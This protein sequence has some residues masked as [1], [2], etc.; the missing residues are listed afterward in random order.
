MEKRKISQLFSHPNYIDMKVDEGG[1]REWRLT[2]MYGEF[3]WDKKQLT[4]DCF[5]GLHNQHNLPWVVI[6]DL[7]EIM[8]DH[9]KEG[10]NPRHQRYLNA[11]SA[12]MDGCDLHDIGYEGE[13]FTW[14]HGHVREILDRAVANTQWMNMMPQATL[15]NLPFSRLDQRPLLLCTYHASQLLPNF[16]PVKRF[17]ARWLSEENF[18]SI[19]HDAWEESSVH[20][21]ATD[22]NS[23][24]ANLHGK[25]HQW[26]CA[27]L[28][29]PRKAR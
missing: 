5:H 12:T 13:L 21:P 3:K 24:L 6:G 14:Q 17:E 10:G 26:D 8:I 1:G 29:K 11:F 25:L 4:W 27:V 15:T 22:V 9:E 7:N 28:K 18:E 23:Q 20:A 2:G 16:K 19:V